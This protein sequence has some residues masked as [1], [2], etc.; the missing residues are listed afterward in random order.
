MN[1]SIDENYWASRA[2]DLTLDGRALID[3]ERVE[4]SDEKPFESVNPATGMTLMSLRASSLADTDRAV[5][6]ARRALVQSWSGL[7]SGDR[8]RLL[9]AFA[10]LLDQH[11]D[12]LGL[13]DT[14]EMGMPI[15][16][17]VGDVATASAMV[18]WCAEVAGKSSDELLPSTGGGIA[19][20]V[21]VPRGVVGAIVPWNFPTFNVISK[22]APALA[23]GNTLVIKPS[24]IASLSTLRI[25]D[26]ILEAGIPSGVV[27]VVPGAGEVAGEALAGH[28]DVDFLSFTGSTRVGR[29]LMELSSSS[30][31]KPLALELGG[32]SPQIVFADTPDLDA[33]AEAVCSTVFWNSGQVCTAGSRLIVE[34]TIQEEFLERVVAHAGALKIGDPLDPMTTHGPLASASQRDKVER[35]VAAAVESGAQ[36]LVGGGRS[37]D[38]PAGYGFEPTIARVAP[39][40]RILNEEIFGPVLSV[41]PFSTAEEAVLLGNDTEYGLAAYVWSGDTH[42]AYSVA[43]HLHCGS[44]TI[45]PSP[46]DPAEVLGGSVEPAG[47]SGFGPEGGFAGMQAYTRLKLI[48]MNL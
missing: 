9:F 44:V 34:A 31:L 38:L 18:R 33:V 6:A 23:T 14:L 4:L 41:Q 48:S 32:K 1:L 35:I 24:E 2:R 15:S 27:N 30:N 45:N 12:E 40:N 20:N 42:Q 26:L 46:D 13:L 5:G 25:A 21:R 8:S 43:R 17:S 19:L 11:A 37:A 28:G 10:D 7:E 29:R 47:L 39:D 36:I 22:I 3:G 16:S